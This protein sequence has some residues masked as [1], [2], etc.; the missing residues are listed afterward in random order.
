LATTELKPDQILIRKK[1]GSSTQSYLLPIQTY[2][3]ATMLVLES[4]VKVAADNT[5][6]YVYYNVVAPISVTFGSLG[7][8]QT[9]VGIADS[10]ISDK[11]TSDRTEHNKEQVNTKGTLIDFAG[12]ESSSRPRAHKKTSYRD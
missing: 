11:T 3:K 7:V 10:V 9:L 4:M 1:E 12:K 6:D 2:I 8:R 5:R